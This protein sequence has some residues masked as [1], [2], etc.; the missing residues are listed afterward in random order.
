[1]RENGS[2][3]PCL[4]DARA[5][6]AVILSARGNRLLLIEALSVCCLLVALFVTV[7]YAISALSLLVVP[8]FLEVLW[9]VCIYLF[10]RFLAAP[11][12]VGLVYMAHLMCRKEEVILS[13]LFFF[14]MDGK[15][16]LHALRMTAPTV[17][18][19]FLA[20]L[21]SDYTVTVLASL[22]PF[23]VWNLPVLA[24]LI[25]AELFGVL[26]LLCLSYSRICRGVCA[27]LAD[28]A[29]IEQRGGG[30]PIRAFGKGVRFFGGFFP[31]ILLG[32]L[33]FGLLL[34]A[35]VLPQMLLAYCCDCEPNETV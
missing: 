7:Q 20:I 6:A 29:G 15:R 31:R 3:T 17:Y 13:D 24:L 26:L 11:L 35:D 30:K 23:G 25:A 28:V 33:T 10:L 9:Y 32:L 2:A 12:L 21:L 8:L 4:R 5:R 22:M 1:M 34:I 27:I 19:I 14:W 16:Y 18:C